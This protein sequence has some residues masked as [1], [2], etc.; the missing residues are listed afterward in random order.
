[1]RF[2]Y[3]IAVLAI[4]STGVAGF[5]NPAATAAAP[6]AVLPA[7]PPGVA[8]E[9]SCASPPETPDA[10]AENRDRFVGLW[11][12]R[13]A[14]S[15]WLQGYAARDSVPADIRDEGF[16]AMSEETQVWLSSCL[17][18][19]MLATTGENPDAEQRGM[20]LTGL[21]LVIFG[22]ADLAQLR[23]EL[24]EQTSAEEAA[25]EQPPVQQDMTSEALET[26]AADLVGEPALTSADLPESDATAPA[27]EVSR[28]L[29]PQ[30]SPELQ[31][32]LGAP[33]VSPTPTALA[34]PGNLLQIFPIPQ[35]LQAV[36]A[37]LQLVSKIQGRLFT[38]PG[39]NLLASAFYKICAESPTMPLSCSVSLPVGLPIPADVNGD[40]FPDVT[41]WLSPLANGL[42]V[43]AKFMVTRLFPGQGT[44]PAHVFAVY[45]TPVGKKRIQFGYDGRASTLANRTATTFKLKNIRSA[46]AGDIN[47]TADI[48][49][50][51]PGSTQSLTFAVK[52]L[53][54]GST[55]VPPSEEDPM[56]GAVQM[57]PV[58]D[59]LTMNAR[60]IHTPERDE[61]IFTVGS[62][63]PTKIDAVIDQATTTTTPQSNRRFTAEVDKLPTSVT[64]NL[65]RDGDKQTIDYT[66]SAPIDLVK[67]SDKAIPDVSQ[68]TSF[69]E[70]IYEVHGVPSNVH[71]DLVKAEDIT[72]SASAKIPEVAFQT[73]TLE[74]GVLQQQISAKAHEIPKSVH[75]TNFTTEDETSFTY[76]ADSELQDV[77]LSMYDLNEDDETNL[78]AKATG[79]PTHM[80]FTQTKSTGVYDFS[81]NDG[82]DLIEASLTRN[83]GMLLPLPGDHATVH[84]VGE[85]LGLDFRLSGFRSAHFDGSE[86]TTVA[87]GLTPGG[88]SFDAIAD[89]DDPDV[90]A[91]LHVAELPSEMAVTISPSAQ[92]TTYTASSAI[93]Q[94]T[95]SFLKRDTGDELGIEIQ[96]I[97]TDISLLFDGTG[98]TIDW[99]ASD[100]TGKV[101]AVAH[102]TPDT[103]GGDRTFDAGLTITSIPR[104][105]DA[106]WAGGNVLFQAPDGIGSIEVQVTNHGTYHPLAGDHLSAYYRQASGD[107]DASLK[108]SNLRKA[109]FTKLTNGDGGGF[110]AALKMGNH[111]S[112]GFAADVVLTSAVLKATGEFTNLPSDLTLRSDGGRITYNGDSNP[113]LTLSVE[114][115]TSA[116]AI[117]ATPAPPTPHG[118]AV[119]D[120]ASGADRAV[121]AWLHLTGLPDSLDL[122]SPA[123]TYEVGGYSPSVATLVVDVALTTL[124]AEPVSLLLQQVVPTAS[125]VD[126]KFGPFLSDTA[127][128]G[129]HTLSLSYTA[130]QTLGALTANAQ[131][132]NTDEAQLSI[133]E[134]PSTINVNAAF[135]S[136]QKTVGVAMSHGISDITA[137]Y[138]K[139][140]ATDFAASVHL[141]DVPSAVDLVIGRASGS[142][143]G[144]NITAPDFTMTASQPGLDIEATAS[145]EIAEP[146]DI[147]AAASLMVTNLGHTVT[148]ALNGTTLNIAST[149]KTE[150]FLLTAAGSVKVDV[151]LGFELLGGFIQ[152]TGSL[153]VDVDIKQLTLGFENASTLQ[154]DLGVTTGLKGDYSSFTFGEDT[155]T[156]VT[157]QDTLKLVATL[158]DPFPNI[159]FTVIHIPTTS[160][161]FENVISS[162]RM[163]TNRLGEVF[164]ATLID[165]LCCTVKA[166]LLARPHA[167]FSS[168]GPSFTVGQPDSDGVHAP[169]WLITPNLNLLGV[170]LPDFVVDV[171]AYFTSPYGRELKGILE[172]DVPA[173]DPW[174]C[175]P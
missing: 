144:T 41:G 35:L 13:V 86:D 69:T 10:T 120:G 127:G 153:D 164:S 102:L 126:F 152:N 171:V 73:K 53:V 76:D 28:S 15:S 154:L 1:M 131:Y 121:K 113:D 36:D 5:V 133:S 40:N 107:L 112:F 166:K 34:A 132:G 83:G 111:G 63:T 24:A 155:K 2:R 137:S 25:A 97:P 22:K 169:A 168:N 38:L 165:I 92:T 8:A 16:H 62:S 47:V 172:C 26:M 124:A 43:G 56:T 142:G 150:K 60:L 143:G 145:A 9:V 93:P 170:S 45:D 123:G 23:E 105:W 31:Q 70:S 59:Q 80:E 82:I 77:E 14:D 51:S 135:G 17:L 151:D 98:S 136:A 114:A 159:D 74:G 46:V 19:D 103:L 79:I 157:L 12:T 175:T 128:D 173:A 156:V 39:L 167:E 50:Y 104:Q 122:N 66:G 52:S 118:V 119:R 125:P 101:A 20:Y 72:Y 11:S 7:A 42:D 161:N 117:A 139:V 67:A 90:R 148:G 99:T 116:A 89:L 65:V 37:V 71:V 54:G 129:T 6:S 174:D 48:L 109:G 134:I 61:D 55:G 49:T 85:A 33:S 57:S 110:E 115:G 27:P 163:A 106:T 162:F 100:T 58:P 75:V 141:S 68:P 96:D 130:N 29:E 147:K 18:D 32:L 78:Q 158:P 160:I 146:A 87:L 95:G 94:I 88:Q 64:V 3:F 21:H 44:L 4:G 149:P 30:A 140:G 84:K 138:K 108:V 91:E 81:S